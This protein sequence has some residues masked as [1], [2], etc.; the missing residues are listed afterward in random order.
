MLT[1]IGLL[2]WLLLRAVGADRG[3][4]R[5]ETLFFSCAAGIS[6]TSLYMLAIGLAGHLHGRVWLV[7][8]AAIATA[9]AMIVL[10]MRYMNRKHVPAQDHTTADGSSPSTGWLWL[11]VPFAL[12]ILLGGTLPPVD[13][14]VREYHLEVPKEFFLQGR[15][16]F[17]P[18]NSYGNMPLGA[19]MLSLA[20]MQWTADWWYGALVGKALIATY[21][22]L[23]ALGLFAAGRRFA[24]V[25]AGVVAALV[26]I[27]I[28]WIAQVSVAGLVE[29]LGAMFLLATVYAVLLWR[30]AGDGQRLPREVLAGFMAGSAV[31]C[32]YPAA[33]SCCCLPARSSPSARGAAPLRRRRSAIAA[34][35]VGAAGGVCPGGGRRLWSMA[36]QELGP[37]WESDVSPAGQ[38]LRWPRAATRSKAGFARAH[39][40]PI[41]NRSIYSSPCW[42][43]GCKALG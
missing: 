28:P 1:V 30:D 32:K 10:A 7:V 21:A 40:R 26:Y 18:H 12:A 31:A 8:P 25:S 33:L 41:T 23:T 39:L 24:G 16:G 6:A 3:L 38:H 13:F 4:A 14:D 27:S 2:G 36:G 37:D 29:G 9:M 20:A 11:G 19:E 35:A 42:V 5:A 22:P 34:F 43:S 15:I 17:L